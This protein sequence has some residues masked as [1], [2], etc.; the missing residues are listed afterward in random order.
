MTKLYAIGHVCHIRNIAQLLMFVHLMPNVRLRNGPA[1]SR[2]GPMFL[3]VAL[4][5]LL[6]VGANITNK[7][8][9]S[10]DMRATKVTTKGPGGT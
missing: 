10:L 7:K 4:C 5:T 9:I 8:K 6:Q 1:K 3:K 2:P